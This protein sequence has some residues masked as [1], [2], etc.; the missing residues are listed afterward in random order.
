MP[1]HSKFLCG[2]VGGRGRGNR[3][4]CQLLR[5]ITDEEQQEEEEM[6]KKKAHTRYDTRR[7]EVTRLLVIIL[8]L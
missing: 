7:S 3:F 5:L 6:E 8:S 4:A 2:S 1:R